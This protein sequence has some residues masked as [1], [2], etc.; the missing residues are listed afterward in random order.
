L[1][2]S[3]ATQVVKAAFALKEKAFPKEEDSS[4][5]AHEMLVSH[6]LNNKSDRIGVCA[7]RGLAKSRWGGNYI[8]LILPLLG[9]GIG[10]VKKHKFIVIISATF[11]SATD[12][13]QE[14]KDL[15]ETLGDSYKQLLQKRIWKADEISFELPN[16]EYI[17][18]VAMGGE[19]KIRGIRRRGARP[20]LLIFDDAEYEELVL[21]PARM[22][23]WKQWV[24]RSAIPSM[25][26]LGA[27]IWIGTPLPNSML[28]EIQ[29]NPKWSFI[30]LPI[31]DEYGTP[32]WIS[33]FPY[34]W[35]QRRKSELKE[36]GEINAWYQEYELKI[37]SEEEQIFKTSM[38]RYVDYSEIENMDLDIYITCD[39]AVSS[40]N[41]ADKTA[42]VVTG[43]DEH[44]NIY[45]LEIFAKRCPPSEQVDALLSM[46]Q[47]W[48]DKSK[49][50]VVLGIERG[51]LKY[52]F[53]DVWDRRLKE[54]NHFYKI[55]K[56]RE[57]DP[58]GGSNAKN[59]RIQQL[60]P[61]MLRG[62]VKF[63]RGINNI[64]ILEEELLAF[65]ISKHDDVSDAFSY[66]FQLVSWREPKQ[67]E[68]VRYDDGG[69]GG[70]CW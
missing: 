56:V 34:S 67:V 46:C 62:S 30:N 43:V 38:I 44:N 9:I 64:N 11:E 61:L 53:M 42:F 13:V 54:L 25:G 29:D 36:M 28:N 37:I 41:S 21:N 3:N 35:I 18:I 14:I 58:Y 22:K 12:M 20:D 27:V 24:T 7:S 26:K 48:F 17:A 50:Q 59:K 8:P 45:V 23:K 4:P 69:F 65:P 68:P 52:S 15:Y 47:R 49:R 33:R 31:H 6:I 1:D 5:Q 57:L 51:S 70:L 55:P 19:G 10:P 39:L 66:I 63:V 60:E 32:A 40:A 2:L 16:G